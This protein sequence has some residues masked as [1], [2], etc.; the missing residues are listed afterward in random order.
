MKK[1]LSLLLIVVMAL[2]LC[3]CGG[4]SKEEMLEQATKLDC[5]QMVRD[6][7]ENVKRAQQ[8]Y[9]GKI[10]RIEN[11]PANFD[12]RGKTLEARYM[13]PGYTSM[14]VKIKLSEEDLLTVND[15]DHIS[16]VG[17]LKINNKYD[18]TL[19]NA[20]LAE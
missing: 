6:A 5:F 7:N 14:M 17:V 20:Y 4:P 9:N 3:A 1:L 13:V 2:A 15:G 12:S 18:A 16:V 8:E 10:V 11:A 19:S